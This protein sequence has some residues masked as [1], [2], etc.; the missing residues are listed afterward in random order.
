ML[1]ASLSISSVATE[2]PSL[3]LDG[4]GGGDQ[5]PHLG[6]ARPGSHQPLQT[7]CTVGVSEPEVK[8]IN[9]NQTFQARK[10]PD[11]ISIL[12]RRPRPPV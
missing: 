8:V 11:L 4:P 10:L 2:L 12:P 1:K 6:A 5:A 3:V 7:A 9:L